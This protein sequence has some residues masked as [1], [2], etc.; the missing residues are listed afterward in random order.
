[1]KNVQVLDG[2]APETEEETPSVDAVNTM[3]TA[4]TVAEALTV[5]DGLEEG[6]TTDKWYFIKGK[7]KRIATTGADVAKYNNINYY[8]TDDG[9][10]E[11][12]VYNGRNLNNTDF[13][14]DGEL[15]V[16]DEVIVVGKL[17]KYKNNKSGAIVPE[18]ASGNY[19]VKLTAGQG[20]T[21]EVDAVN[22]LDT[23]ITVAEALN[24]V[25]ALADGQTTEKW[26]YLKGKV[27]KINTTGA[28]VAKYKNINYYITD[29]G[30]NEIQVY[31][32][33]NLGNTD[34]TKD[35][36]LNVGDEVI[37]VGKLMKYINTKTNA[38][39]PEVADGN[40]IVKFVSRAENVTPDNPDVPQPT[41]NN[42]LTNGDF[43]TWAD[44]LPTGWKSAS[45]ASSANLSQST[46]AHGGSYSVV[47]E[48]NASSNKRLASKE[49]TLKAGDYTFSFYAKSTTGDP[50]QVRPGMVPITDKLS[51]SYGDYASI[52]NAGWTLVSY[53]F[54]LSSESTV[55]LV[56]M[57]PK[58]STHAT[59][60]N[61]LIDDAMLTTTNGGLAGGNTEEPTP[62]PSTEVK[63]ISVAEFN[64]AAVDANVWY[65]LTGT[66]KNLKDGD[67]YGNFDLEDS[68]G[69]VYVYGVLSEKGGAKRQF[70]TLA[71]E[72]GI[73][74]GSTLTIIGTR[75]DYNGKIEVVNAYFVSVSN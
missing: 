69:S 33:R 1:V 13:T 50:A 34:F 19:I 52:N 21:D 12:Q 7:V 57:N 73:K 38:V 23:P 58:T 39:V 43:E 70:Q 18:V 48:G 2:K 72:K 29:D 8:I 14:Q 51:Y 9:S 46:D 63:A 71:A 44:G 54:T 11:I 15:N 75:G 60:Q 41:G 53:S 40:Y 6:Q 68:T 27:K 35:G 5:V 61:V 47:V 67:Q 22:T 16:G 74:N 24:V 17:M 36:E 32:G 64:A 49:L 31:R 45:T 28:D 4:I 42:L 26:Y 25:N 62:Q 10:N 66:V 65:Q 55:C 37:V 20:N 56:V 59:A 3:E 30:S